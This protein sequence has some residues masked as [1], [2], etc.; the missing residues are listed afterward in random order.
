MPS[1]FT[2]F[3]DNTLYFSPQNPKTDLGYYTIEGFLSDS[4]LTTPF[5]FSV[6]VYNL[7]PKFKGDTPLAD[8]NVFLYTLVTYQMPLPE[9]PE[10][11]PVKVKVSMSNELPLPEFI[12]FDERSMSMSIN[13]SK[14]LY[15]D[16]Y[17]IEVSL[18]D[19]YA[20]PYTEF[21]KII[22]EDPLASEKL[23]KNKD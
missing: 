17:T 18:S 3:S 14:A 6:Y 4:Q 19:G 7:S 8:Q 13:P 5:K 16:T 9:D 1:K 20:R 23:K 2:K 15:I 21:F 11:L 22:V 12:K 10:G